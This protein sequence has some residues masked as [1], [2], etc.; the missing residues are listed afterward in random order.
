[1]AAA[2]SD[3]VLHNGPQPLAGNL[4]GPRKMELFRTGY[5]GPMC[6]STFLAKKHVRW[7]LKLLTAGVVAK[8]PVSLQEGRWKPPKGTNRTSKSRKR[9][10]RR[11]RAKALQRERIEIAAR[12][13]MLLKGS[14]VDYRSEQG[15]YR[16]TKENVSVYQARV[17]ENE[18]ITILAKGDLVW[19]EET[20]WVN[21]VCWARLSAGGPLEEEGWIVLKASDKARGRVGRHL[22]TDYTNGWVTCIEKCDCQEVAAIM[23]PA[24][25]RMCRWKKGK[26]VEVVG[27]A[28]IKYCS[29]VKEDMRRRWQRFDNF[30]SWTNDMRQVIS[31]LINFV[32][33]D[34]F[35]HWCACLDENTKD[36]M[37]DN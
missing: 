18:A 16:V 9:R 37:H 35:K 31:I 3:L 10:E 8:A 29:T 20:H 32:S 28:S 22:A 19:V 4:K 1:M 2:S 30:T 5:Y 14:P 21:L 15:P 34:Q 33:E 13:G 26:G 36:S 12:G 27:P 11:A 6:V 24:V 23:V 25:R 7:I 17:E